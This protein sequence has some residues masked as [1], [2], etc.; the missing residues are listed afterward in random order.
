MKKSVLRHIFIIGLPPIENRKLILNL[1]KDLRVQQ[2]GYL[3]FSYPKPPE[4]SNAV[5]YCLPEQAPEQEWCDGRVKMTAETQFLF[6]VTNCQPEECLMVSGE[7]CC[8]E[9]AENYDMAALAYLGGDDRAK[10][11]RAAA[12]M[13]AEGFEEIGWYFLQHVYERHHG[14]PWTILETPRCVL[15]EFSM[16]RLQELFSLYENQEMTKYIEPLFPYEKEREYQKAYIKN[17]Y[18]FYG[19]GMWIVC[20]RETDALIGR[21]G[22]EYREDSGGCLE[23]GYAIGVPYQ[24]QGYARETCQAV[25]AYAR[26]ELGAD[27]I[28]CLIQRENEKSFRL[29]ERL[30]FTSTEDVYLEGKRMIKCEKLL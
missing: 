12:D 10:E 7:P 9:L 17:M 3:C 23:L 16:E 18:G 25:L 8:L 29:A 6:D 24:K 11:S 19:F 15:R 22:L 5:L 20:D 4:T 27:K 14:L 28:C 2:K 13:Y 26:E 21:V 30:G 1:I